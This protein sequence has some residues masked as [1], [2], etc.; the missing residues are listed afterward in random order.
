MGRGI[1]EAACGDVWPAHVAWQQQ[2]QQQQPDAEMQGRYGTK[3]SPPCS[4]MKRKRSVLEIMNEWKKQI[5][6]TVDGQ[7]IA[8]PKR[9]HTVNINY[10]NDTPHLPAPLLI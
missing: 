2:Q 1:A 5:I 7:N 4:S 3:K 10:I 8:P 6:L 9:M